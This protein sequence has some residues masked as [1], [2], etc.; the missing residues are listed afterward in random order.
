MLYN[1]KIY[2]KKVLL[3]VSLFDVY[4][5]LW[6]KNEVFMAFEILKCTFMV[7]SVINMT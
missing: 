3:K 4:Q 7:V 5:L 6:L 2:L 1:I